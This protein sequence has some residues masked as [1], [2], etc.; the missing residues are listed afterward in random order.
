[1]TSQTRL[2]DIIFIG[3][4]KTATSYIYEYYRQHPNV[5]TSDQVKELYYYDE[6]YDKGEDWY[7]NNFSP[8]PDHLV[9]IDVAPSYMND[10]NAIERIRQDNPNAKIIITLR[11]PVER[12]SSHV[13]HHIRH[14]QHYSGF[15][16]LIIE[17]PMVVQGSNFEKYI[18][19]WVNTFGEENVF[20]LD[21]RE[22]IQD[23]AG[24]MRKICNLIN[25]PF[26]SD[27]D[28]NHKVNAA[29]SA[30]SPLL[31]RTAHIVMRF[32]IRNGLGSV[33]DFVKKSGA[34][35]LIFKESSTF[36]MSEK[37]IEKASQ[38]FKKSTQYYNDRFA[39]VNTKPS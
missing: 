11:D 27:F 10:P 16:N 33:I 37:D 25:V 13:K 21:Y 30:R 26:N 3:P 9:M 24:F 20:V 36:K 23:S 28:F 34:K 8:K 31:M 6:H 18:N 22:L 14:G 39:T 29:G 15:D 7:L 2:P 1:M 35:S 12:F 5:T 4:L 38:Y 17:H 32:C 19:K